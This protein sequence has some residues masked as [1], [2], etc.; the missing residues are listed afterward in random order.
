M[1]ESN[2]IQNIQT[3]LSN[4]FETKEEIKYFL[5]IIGDIILKK[6]TNI[7]IISN[8]AKNLLRTI[9]NIGRQYF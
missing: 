9:E 7:N 3:I 1:P 4:I 5:T 8:N 6:P 2:T